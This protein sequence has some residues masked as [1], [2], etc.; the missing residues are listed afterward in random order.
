[1]KYLFGPVNSRR[2]GR[3][4][5]ID[6][7]PSKICNLNCIYCEVGPTTDLTCE[8]REYSPT[9][10]ILAEIDAFLDGKADRVFDVFTITG[11]GEPTLHS[12]IGQIIRHLKARTDKPVVVLTNGSLLSQPAVRAE[13]AAADIVVP[14]LDAALPAAYRK[15]NR[16]AACAALAD[17][18]SGLQVFS[19]EFAGEVWLEILL[20]K[21]MNDSAADVAALRE[22]IGA[23]LPARVQ[24]NTVARPPVE[25]FAR[26]LSAADLA[27]VAAE[28]R[29][30]Y[31][32]RVEVL[33]A[34]Q[35]SVGDSG[36]P[37]ALADVGQ[38]EAIVEMLRR[39]PCTVVDISTA[40]NLEIERIVPLLDEL[41]Q[42]GRIRKM[43]H[44]LDV[45]YHA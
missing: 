30:G 31:A 7:L 22:A 33:T 14:S 40:L 11:S 4:L 42:A 16:P 32:G 38:A 36:Q 26:P 37:H 2:L 3:S 1:M 43:T 20:V 12:G 24:L 23:I 15:V 10:A 34:P 8:R 13:L 28:L 18:L 17:L 25:S 35:S 21:G 39:R 41:A 9:A 19:R 45:Y 44:N 27:A 6:L 29:R 5:G